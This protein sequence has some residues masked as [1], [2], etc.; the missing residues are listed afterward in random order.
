MKR[1]I[2][3]DQAVP[4]AGTAG[5]AVPEAAR[6]PLRELMDDRLLDALLERSRDQA[7]GLRLTGEGSMLGDLVRAVLE[8]ALEARADRAPGLRKSG[9]GGAGG[10]ARNG[11]IAKTV[12][13]GVGPVPLQVPRDRA[14]T[15]EPLL[16]PKRAGRVAGGL[17]DMVISLYAHG[18]SVRDIIHHLGRSTGPSC[19]RRRSPRI[20]DAVL[21][22][23][24]A[25]QSRPL[26]PVYAAVFLDAIVVK[27]RDGQVVQNKPAYVAIGVD[28]DGEKHVLGIWLSRTP[29]GSAAEG[30][31][32]RFWGSV[33][34]DLRNR[35]VRDILIACV[36]GLAGFADA[37]TAAFPQTVVQRC[38]VHYADLRVM[39]TSWRD[40]QVAA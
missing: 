27:V 34:A 13:T 22:E 6:R 32:A 31:G 37:I 35:G 2:S 10:N 25:W 19:P 1:T 17:D 4:A 9:R 7:G 12:Q 8:R 26:D 29:P 33:M 3:E 39:P 5:S 20:T 11:T 28:A 38:V 30:E 15:F 21:E 18:M 40:L 24:Q 36:D 23:V 16:V 14:G